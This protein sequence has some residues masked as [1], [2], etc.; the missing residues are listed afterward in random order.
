MSDPVVLRVSVDFE[1]AAVEW[2]LIGEVDSLLFQLTAGVD[3]V[4]GM[5]FVKRP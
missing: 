4:D 3:D 5:V 1:I 2:I